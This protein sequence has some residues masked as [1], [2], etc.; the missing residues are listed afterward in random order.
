[1][2][3]RHNTEIGQ[4][5]LVDKSVAGWMME[6]A[7]LAPADRVLEIGPGTGILTKSILAA[8]CARVDAVETDIRLKEY[9]EPMTASDDR[10]RLH[11]DDAVTF[12]YS[13]LDETPTRIIANLPYHITTPLLWHLLESFAGSDMRYM[14]LM[15]QDESASRIAAGA[16][17][18]ESGPLSVTIAAAGGAVVLRKVPRTAFYP[19]PRVDSAIA[20]ITMRGED[21]PHALLPRDAAWRKLLSGSFAMRRKTLANNWNGAFGVKKDDC[22]EILAAHSLGARARP[23]E[24]TLPDW[25]SLREDSRL[26]SYIERRR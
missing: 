16:G 7:R 23:E 10:L 12:D 20:E 11:W 4:N 26:T 1:M 3:F 22:A 21:N 2:T 13:A 15:V 6:R 24:L 25:L 17:N 8:G 9:L 5:F 19:S 14:L 18:R